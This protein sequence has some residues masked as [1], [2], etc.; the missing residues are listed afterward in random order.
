MEGQLIAERIKDLCRQKGISVNKA[1]IESGAGRGITTHFRR[2]SMPSA[3]RVSA[4]ADYLGVSTNYLLGLPEKSE[5]DKRIEEFMKKNALPA[6]SRIPIVGTI[7][8]GYPVIAEEFLEGFTLY[9]VQN[10]EEYFA[11]RVQG[12]SMINAGIT[13]GCAVIIHK[14]DYAENGQIVA[15]M[16]DEQDAT[17]KRFRQQGR[18]IMLM[19]ENSNYDPIILDSSDFDPD[20][21]RAHILG[22]VKAC[23]REFD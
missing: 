13:P 6:G 3:D 22:T 5:M 14:Q 2:G 9:D 4:L 19:P 15:C 21:G 12:D 23:I 11:L 20:H 10:P 18:T 7:R 8:A 1:E 16:V 17:L